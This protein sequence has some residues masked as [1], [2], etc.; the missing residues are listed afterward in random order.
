[1]ADVGAYWDM[2]RRMD[3]LNI[4]MVAA[5]LREGLG[6]LRQVQP[7]RTILAMDRRYTMILDRQGRR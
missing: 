5:G 6:E 4:N 7:L 1:M 3:V 2:V